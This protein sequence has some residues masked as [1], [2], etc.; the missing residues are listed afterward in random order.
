[1]SVVDVILRGDFDNSYEI[2]VDYGIMDEVVSDL[3]D[4][5][6]GCTPVVICDENTRELF[7]HELVEKLAVKGVDPLL[8][9][10]PA[11]ENSKS[12]DV[13]GSLLEAMLEAGITRQDVVVALGGG[14]VGDLSGYVAGS[15]MRG[16][17]FVQVPTTLLSQ[18]DSAVGG[19]VAVNISGG[20]N[21]CGMFYQPRRVYSDISALDT[22]PEREILSGL[23]E[24]VKHGFIYD[25]D[26]VEFLRDNAEK[27]LKLDKE[28][29]SRVVSR[30]CEIKADVVS[31]DEKEGGMRRIL[32][33]GHT[34]GHAI[35]TFAGYKKSHGECV[36]YG[37]R[38]VARACSKAGILSGDD[39]ELHD[40]VMDRLGLATGDIDIDPSLIMELM[41]RDKKVKQGAVV[42]VALDKLGHAV[43]RE[44]F[45]LELIE[46][47]LKDLS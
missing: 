18:V 8:L 20:K 13:F 17:N 28:V 39:L 38:I 5:K 7:G 9:T 15:Y 4:E 21:Y 22:L 31:R 33:Y 16:I 44:D 23:G 40:E 36:A 10:V 30:C 43:V 6:F 37:M 45:P 46:A 2:T 12:L 47:E 34:V 32:N 25:R 42:I 19:K 41:K 3:C 1:M 24:V 29:M 26:F 35:E 14:V 11:G 27:V